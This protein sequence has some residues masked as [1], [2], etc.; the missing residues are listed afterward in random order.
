M[1]SLSFCGCFKKKNP[2]FKD[3]YVKI[4]EIGRGGFGCA[5]L[6]K[7][8]K[9]KKE[10]IVKVIEHKRIKKRKYW[11]STLDLPN[12]IAVLQQLSHKNIVKLLTFYN[13]AEHIELV[14]EKHGDSKDLHDLRMSVFDGG[15]E[16]LWSFIF[17]QVVAAV[18]YMHSHKFT[19]GDIKMENVI[20]DRQFRVKLIDFGAARH[21][22]DSDQREL[23]FN[24]FCVTKLHAPPEII[25]K[26]SFTGF[27][28]DVWQ[29]GILLFAL[30]F[31]QLPFSS[32]ER[33]VS[34][35]LTFPPRETLRFS[36][37]H[38]SLLLQMLMPHVDLRLTISQVE[39]NPW[40]CQEGDK[41]S[42]D[43]DRIVV[44]PDEWNDD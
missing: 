10:V 35:C 2:R 20:V 36:P 32:N 24:Y 33:I 39:H 37:A 40:V 3:K 13:E 28:Q 12:E 34:A 14:M 25:N 4:K 30:L 6:A 9:S 43:W 27:P 19:H 38:R 44:K 1:A 22:R 11:D 5:H 31:K 21:W 18:S 23:P 17:R 7:E 26:H 16:F 8:K 15:S 29:L 42:L 41:R